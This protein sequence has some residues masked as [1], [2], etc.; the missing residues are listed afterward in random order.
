MITS[1]SS[2]FFITVRSIWILKREVEL[3][4]TIIIPIPHVVQSIH[5]EVGSQLSAHKHPNN[6]YFLYRPMNISCYF[7]ECYCGPKL[8]LIGLLKFIGC[9]I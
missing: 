1:F 6:S 3:H 7:A 8:K 5:R 9:Y 2:Y 4:K